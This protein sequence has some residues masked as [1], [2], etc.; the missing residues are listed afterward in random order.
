MLRVCQNGSILNEG[1]TKNS[2]RVP[3]Y[4]VSE[5]NTM[6]LGVKQFLVRYPEIFV[7]SMS[8]TGDML[9]I[10]SDANGLSE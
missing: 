5:Q 9:I 10:Q 2:N 7:F 3:F 1:D 6:C 4:W 8:E